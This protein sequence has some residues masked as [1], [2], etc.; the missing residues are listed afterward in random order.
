MQKSVAHYINIAVFVAV[1][2][3]VAGCGNKAGEGWKKS[4]TDKQRSID[5][6]YLKSSVKPLDKGSVRVKTKLLAHKGDTVVEKA[7]NVSKAFSVETEG[8]IYCKESSFMVLS[9]E[10]LDKQGI[11]LKIEKDGGNMGAVVEIKPGTAL[12]PMIQEVCKEVTRM[13]PVQTAISSAQK[14]EPVNPSAKPENKPAE[15]KG[16]F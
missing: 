14:K 8:V 9:K 7:T 15:K 1:L 12:Y 3:F 2:I 11:S 10:Y 5:H 4:G 6:Y 13:K 16:R